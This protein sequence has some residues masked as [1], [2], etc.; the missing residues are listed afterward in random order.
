MRGMSASIVYSSSFGIAEMYEVLKCTGHDFDAQ[1]FRDFAKLCGDE[2]VDLF[3]DAAVEHVETQTLTCLTEKRI[4][5]RAKGGKTRLPLTPVNRVEKVS[6]SGGGHHGRHIS[7][8]SISGDYICLPELCEPGCNHE[9]SYHFCGSHYEVTYLTKPAN[10][11]TRLKLAVF[12]VALDLYDGNPIRDISNII[13]G[14]GPGKT[15]QFIAEVGGVNL[16][17]V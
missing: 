3:L 2:S 7:H 17:I 14:V 11:T 13:S 12:Q 16:R 5:A 10:C 6:L 8:Y 15:S 9:Y 4:L 1:E